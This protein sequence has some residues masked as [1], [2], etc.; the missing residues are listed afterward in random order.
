MITPYSRP[1]RHGAE[2]D[3]EPWSSAWSIRF[4]PGSGQLH[5]APLEGRDLRII[6]IG[7]AYANPER[8]VV[9]V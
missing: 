3:P 8:T 2:I 7:R 9:I 5:P 6:P 1:F 4:V